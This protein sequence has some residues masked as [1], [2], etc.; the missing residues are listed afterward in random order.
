MFILWTWEQ[1]HLVASSVLHHPKSVLHLPKSTTTCCELEN[2]FLLMKLWCEYFVDFESVILNPPMHVP[3][4]VGTLNPP[5]PLTLVGGGSP[6]CSKQPFLEIAL[7]RIGTQNRSLLDR[8]SQNRGAVQSS[9]LPPPLPSAPMA[10]NP[11]R[12][13]NLRETAQPFGGNQIVKKRKL[14]KWTQRKL[15]ILGGLWW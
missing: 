10:A 4:W 2:L 5:T 1:C 8:R 6:K 15:T 12:S 3:I 9:P 11:L 7:D 13:A 14:Q